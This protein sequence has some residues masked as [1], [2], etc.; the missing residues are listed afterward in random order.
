MKITALIENNSR[1]QDLAAQYGLS[2]LVE[3]G[4]KS[5]IVDT[6]QDESALSNFRLL[7]YDEKQIDAI[8]ISHN[9]FDHIGGLQSF[10]DATAL[11]K[12]PVYLSGG[13]GAELFTKRLLR[14]RKLVSRNGLVADNAER[15]VRVDDMME[16]FQSVYVCRVK[17]PDP[18]FIC[19]DKKLRMT[20]EKGRLVC[21]DFLHE[22]YLAV[23][24]DGF[25]KIV[26]SCSHNGV[27]NIVRDAQKR[28]GLPVAAF[29]GG[30]HMRGKK[31]KSLNCTRKFVRTVSEELNKLNVNAVYTCHC[32]GSV[33]F[34]ILDTV[35]KNK[36]R[37]FHTGDTFKV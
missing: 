5:I 28:F 22:V 35:Y 18:S 6:G 27:I 37:Y 31:A 36:A 7:G 34:K 32:T 25:L 14:R 33:A 9:H 30:L 12:A 26:S 4:D 11:Q 8:M 13:I 24:E 2:L 16:I 15:V 19:K 10:I 21:D 17:N 1:R 20:D 3:V 29:V 23:I